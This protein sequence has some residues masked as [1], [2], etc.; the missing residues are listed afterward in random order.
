MIF[1]LD[2]NVILYHLSGKLK[3][4]L[5]KGEFL[6]SIVTEIE[7]MSFKALTLGE[8]AAIRAFLSKVTIVP[9]EDGLKR[10]HRYAV[11]RAPTSRCYCRCDGISKQRRVAKPRLTTAEIE[12]VDRLGAGAEAILTNPNVREISD[13][14][15]KSLCGSSICRCCHFRRKPRLD[16]NEPRRGGITGLRIYPWSERAPSGPGRYLQMM[17]IAISN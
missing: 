9:L 12:A 17:H 3:G 14:Y 5:P 10:R 6:V 8:A 1:A 13:Q 7:L 15:N 2:T 16:P 4:P 11:D